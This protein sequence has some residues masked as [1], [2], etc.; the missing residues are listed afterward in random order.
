MVA[1]K[2]HNEEEFAAWQKDAS[3]KALDAMPKTTWPQFVVRAVDER[4]DPITDYHLELYLVRNGTETPLWFDL[5]VHAYRGDPSLRCYHVNLTKLTSEMDNAGEGALWAR[6]IASSG[7]ALVGYHGINSDKLTQDT[8]TMNPE[9]VWDA[10][11]ALP[12]VVG[13][14]QI[15]LF[16]PVYDSIRRATLKPRSPAIRQSI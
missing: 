10:K 7:S 13:P 11:I 2:V 4:G 1:L 14:S 12:T 15:R 3:V 16:L 8:K 5:D 6:V 9:G